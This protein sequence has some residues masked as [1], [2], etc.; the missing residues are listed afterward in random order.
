MCWWS[1]SE[2]QVLTY[3]NSVD[4]HGTLTVWHLPKFLSPVQSTQGTGLYFC[5]QNISTWII[6]R[7]S[8]YLHVQ[9][10]ILEIPTPVKNYPVKSSSVN[11]SII[12]ILLHINQNFQKLMLK[13][14]R[15]SFS[16]PL[17]L[18][19]L[20]SKSLAYLVTTNVC[21]CV[22]TWRLYIYNLH[23]FPTTHTTKPQLSPAW[24][25]AIIS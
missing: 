17:L 6:S 15:S 20:E 5:L 25:N 7:H 22:Y 16:A 11:Q 4:P 9:I 13:K 1:F 18:S 2:S 23:S 12:T 24:N 19:Q 3:F 8:K 10:L 14:L 21:V